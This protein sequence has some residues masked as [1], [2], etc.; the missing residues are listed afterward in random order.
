MPESEFQ[1]DRLTHAD[2]CALAGTVLGWTLLALV[3][4]PRGDFPLI[5]DWA[6]GLQVKMLVEQGSIRF[7]DWNTA[8]G[9]AQVGWGC[10]FCL[11][12]GFSFT[13]IRLST[14]TLGLVGLVSLYLLMRKSERVRRS[15]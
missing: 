8:T 14:L 12:E 1:R 2:I 4:D 3:I 13:A 5:D 11:P 15:R 10:V 7:T 9:I 6:Y